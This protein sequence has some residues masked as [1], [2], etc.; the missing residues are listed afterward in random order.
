[1]PARSAVPVGGDS[2][3]YFCAPARRAMVGRESAVRAAPDRRRSCRRALSCRPSLSTS[4]RRAQSGERRFAVVDVPALGF[5]WL[6]PTSARLESLAWTSRS[7]QETSSPM[8]SSKL[9][10]SSTTGGIQSIY[11]FSHRGNQLSQQIAYRLPPPPGEPGM[12]WQTSDEATYTTMRAEHGRSFRLVC[13]VRRNRQPRRIAR[14]RRTTHGTIPPD[15]ASMGRQSCDRTGSRTR[16]SRRAA[17]RS[18][19]FV[20]L[21][22]ASPGPTPPPNCFAAWDSFALGQTPRAWKRR[23]MSTSK[24]PVAT[25]PC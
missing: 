15:A 8:S 22:Y 18:L 4:W 24:A 1:M 16:R 5:A 6:E 19:E 13:G 20:L 11:D 14:R 21:R 12:E 25:S 7:R 3:A 9:T 10:V 17:G 23:S 2:A